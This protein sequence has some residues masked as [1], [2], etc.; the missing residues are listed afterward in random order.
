MDDGASA[1]VGEERLRELAHL[2]YGD[3]HAG[4]RLV[5]GDNAAVLTSLDRELR[6]RV[7]CIYIDPPYNSAERWVHY[8]DRLDH[9]A[10]LAAR[11][12]TLRALW[13]LLRDDGSLWISIDDGSMHYLKVL[14]DEVCGRASFVTTVVWEHRTS[15]ENRR[16]FSNNHEYLLV[17][18]RSPERFGAT[19]NL[20]RA[21]P[22]LRARYQSPDDDPRG[23]W[24]SGSANAQAGL[25]TP[26]QFY[27]LIAP[28]GRRHVP[29]KGRC[30]VYTQDRM[31]ALIGS[32]QV[33]F[34]RDG[35]GVPRLKR[36]LAD[37]RLTVT[38]ETLWGA[39]LAGTTRDAK[40]HLLS[41]LPD[42]EVFETP[43]PE[44]LIARVVEIAT[45]PGDL[46][47]DAYLGSGTTAAVAMK[48]G[49]RWLGIESGDHV[50]SH[51]VARLRAVVDG[52]GGGLSAD[53]GW[54]GGGGSRSSVTRPRAS[55]W[56]PRPDARRRRGAPAASPGGRG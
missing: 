35:N 46:V 8:D 11:A 44:Q 29:P 37:A 26:A 47:L 43:K 14:A 49:R 18:A 36:Y 3:R 5:Q 6:G 10:W 54:R 13:P 1:R 2:S 22:E 20:L 45:D 50:I 51:C 12:R 23:P 55:S 4:N 21:G 17:Y 56:R 24:Q 30:W 32:G 19:R 25:A 41:L 52:E 40:R 38:P 48:L 34:G 15:R 16:A 53:V 31:R 33:W 39:E 9:D 42:A 27:E 28:N 7:R